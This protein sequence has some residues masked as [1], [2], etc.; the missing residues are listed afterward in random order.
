ME[1]TDPM[2]DQDAEQRTSLAEEGADPVDRGELQPG[3][4]N[5][6]EAD[7]TGTIGTADRSVADDPDRG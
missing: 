4:P 2:R 1:H 3:R 6:P 7:P 5:R